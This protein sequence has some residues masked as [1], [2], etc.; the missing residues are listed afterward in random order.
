VAVEYPRMLAWWSLAFTFV[1]LADHAE[2]SHHWVR[3]KH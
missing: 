3:S 1:P 2:N